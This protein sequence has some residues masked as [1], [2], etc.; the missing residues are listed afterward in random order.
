MLYCGATASLCALEL[1]THSAKLPSDMIV[2]QARV[3]S[4]ANLTKRRM[5]GDPS[6]PSFPLD[7]LTMQ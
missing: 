2:V 1:L 3:H 4:A 6:L 7:D 5:T